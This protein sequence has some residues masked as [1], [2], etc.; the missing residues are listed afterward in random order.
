MLTRSS[1]RRATAILVV[2]GALAV[3]AVVWLVK[4]PSPA[5]KL[6]AGADSAATAPS[7]PSPRQL[8]SLP[9][10]TDPAGS[11][12]AS[13][14][15]AVDAG[16]QAAGI[17]RWRSIQIEEENKNLRDVDEYLFGYFKLPDDVR[18]SVR[19]FHEDY[20]RRVEALARSPEG[21]GNRTRHE[22]ER[23]VGLGRI[24]GDQASTFIDAE[25]R[26]MK[27]LRQITHR[28]NLRKPPRP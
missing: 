10:G 23:K 7:A 11:P 20:S 14:G 13:A 18:A 22:R 28:E 5:E 3:A 6:Q 2:L 17:R 4:R 25:Y 19:Q 27:R 15:G 16:G 1:T 12:D 9:R 24:L 8:V 21:L 26:E